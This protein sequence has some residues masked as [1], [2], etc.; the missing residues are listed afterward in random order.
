[1][2]NK[3]GFTLVELLVVISIIATLL[4]I[5]MPALNKVRKSARKTIC[6][7]NLHNL[8]NTFIM[9]QNN[10]GAFPVAYW[11]EDSWKRELWWEPLIRAGIIQK[12]PVT[13]T[14]NPKGSGN[15]DLNIDKKAAKG[16]TCPEWLD[17]SKDP[18]LGM[19]YG[20]GMAYNWSLSPII[21]NTGDPQS[22]ANPLYAGRIPKGSKIILIDSP[23]TYYVTADY[24]RFRPWWDVKKYPSY[25]KTCYGDIAIWHSGQAV[26]GWTD[27]HCQA[28]IAKE[29]SPEMLTDK[30]PTNPTYK[31]RQTPGSK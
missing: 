26:S 27:G 30:T 1:M 25:G 4:S 5:L 20:M 19:G 21:T 15:W 18:T 22:D 24:A 6:M 11:D 13:S 12:D 23:I 7:T 16:Y 14:E 8:N 31:T 10:F 29:Y 17:F 28:K 9:Y 3:K 2:Q